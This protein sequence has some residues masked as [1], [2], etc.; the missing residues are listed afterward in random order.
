MVKDALGSPR[1]MA[2]QTGSLAGMKR[3][4]FIPF[5]EE[6]FAGAG[7]RTTGMGYGT[8]S[9][10][11]RQKFTGKERDVEAGLDYFEARYYSGVQGRF[12]SPDEFTGGPHELFDFAD[13]TSENPMLYASL[14]QPQSLNKYQ[15]T[16]NNPLSLTDPNGHCPLCAAA[17]LTGAEMELIPGAQPIATGIIIGAGAIALGEGGYR[18]L[19]ARSLPPPKPIPD[20][21]PSASARALPIVP[22][23]SRTGPLSTYCGKGTF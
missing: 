22:A 12:T 18:L 5:G 8:S 6:V 2:D 16:Y 10:T 20:Q 4:D 13:D 21:A 15:Y 3:R 19:T 14:T 23:H 9:D 17:A 7:I 11:T 1:M